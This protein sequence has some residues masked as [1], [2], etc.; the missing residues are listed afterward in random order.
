MISA[1][2]GPNIVCMNIND[3]SESPFAGC[4]IEG[5]TVHRIC[6][7]S[8]IIWFRL[9]R[10]PILSISIQNQEEST[11]LYIEIL[12]KISGEILKILSKL[13]FNSLLS[14]LG[15]LFIELQLPK[16]KMSSW[17][18]IW[19]FSQILMK[20]LFSKSLNEAN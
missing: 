12:V 7:A 2:I 17:P 1:N 14:F 13:S 8:R 18:F 3:C 15:I 16:T 11:T 5:L 10:L 9:S 20:L 6:L 4:F 19:S